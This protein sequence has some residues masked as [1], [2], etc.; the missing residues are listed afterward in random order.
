MKRILLVLLAF[1]TLT[2]SALAIS[3][4]DQEARNN[5]LH[6]LG[7]VDAGRYEQAHSEL[8]TRV[9]RGTKLEDFLRYMRSRR[10][11][12][13]SAI[14]RTFWQV[15]AFRQL[16]GAPDGNYQRITFK[17]RF[18]RKAQAV[19]AVIVTHESGRWQVSG[20]KFW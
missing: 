9:R 3:V 2:Q 20:F 11:P 12:L 14:S 19:E 13:G 15:N 5:A 8:A 1:A 17:S 18:T 16:I 10:A 7:L 4:S 6:W